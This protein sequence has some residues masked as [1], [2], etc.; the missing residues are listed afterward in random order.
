MALH[1]VVANARD[2]RPLSADHLIAPAVQSDVEAARSE[3]YLLLG[4]VPGR[5]GLLVVDVDV[6]AGAWREEVADSLGPPLCEVRS[7]RG[8]HLYYRCH[9]QV[10]NRNWEGG[11]IRCTSGYA[12]LW[13]EQA[14]LAALENLADAEPVDTAAWPIGRRPGPD[15]TQRLGNPGQ[16]GRVRAAL[17]AL[18]CAALGY[19]DWLYVGFGLHW[20]EANG[21][22]RDGLELWRA[23][24]EKDRARYRPGECAYKW[25][26]FD[27]GKQPRRRTLATLFWLADQ[28]GWQGWRRPQARQPAAARAH[29]HLNARQLQL[30][31]DLTALAAPGKSGRLTVS[32]AHEDLA[33]LHNVSRKTIVRD[34]A[35]L[36]ACGYLRTVGRRTV[37]EP[38]GG[39][40]LPVYRPT[41]PDRERWL[42]LALLNAQP[43]EQPCATVRMPGEVW[44]IFAPI[45]GVRALPLLVRHQAQLDEPPRAPP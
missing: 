27:A 13:D 39:F 26:T 21:C 3:P 10:G 23:W 43:S 7:R 22:V 12:V 9:E 20:G 37:R 11:E 4:H 35:R 14:V 34:F 6:D 45:P 42:L 19:D 33:R 25:R 8:L 2:K 32:A 31:S 36:K 5:A 41:S 16:T 29:P 38:G 28:H 1:Y 18:D 40:V 17:Q 44:D 24:S 30:H 15:G